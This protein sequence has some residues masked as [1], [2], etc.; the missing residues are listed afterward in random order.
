MTEPPVWSRADLL[1]EGWTSRALTRAVRAGILLRARCDVYLASGTHADVVDACR[2]GGILACTSELSRRGVFVL[3]GSRLHVQVARSSGRHRRLAR[4]VRVHWSRGTSQ[5]VRGCATVD[6]IPALADSVR[7]QGVRAAVASIDSALH[8]G[9]LREDQVA[10]LFDALPRRYRALRGLIDGRSE[11]G[12]ESLIR[13][14][15][16]ALGC[17]FE[18]QVWISGVGRVDFLVDGWLIVECDSEAHHSSWDEQRRDRRRDQAAAAL[19]YA[20]YRPIAEDIMWHRDRVVAAV[21]GLCA[22]G[23]R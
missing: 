17:G 13:L 11:S 1:R 5:V 6:I 14:I 8:S 12:P 7:C 21:R 23:H 9:A 16:R 18:S 2:L 19:G 4:A 10:D 15:L 3:D 20:T 22:T